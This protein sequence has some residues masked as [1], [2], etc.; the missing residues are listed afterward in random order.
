MLFL[1]FS[2]FS[3]NDVFASW[4]WNLNSNSNPKNWTSMDI[5]SINYKIDVSEI[6]PWWTFKENKTEDRVKNWL[7]TII[8]KLMI[9]FWIL[10]LFVMTIWSW[11]MILHNWEEEV[12]NKW[13][14]IF[15]MWIISICIALSSYLLVELVKF[16]IYS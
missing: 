12:L 3:W 11:Y 14:R 7:L 10:A 2:V 9:P 5:T 16:I 6:V 1:L 8:Q 15:K 4:S 13:K